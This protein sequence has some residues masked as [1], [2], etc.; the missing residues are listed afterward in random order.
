MSP[1]DARFLNTVREVMG[2][3]PIPD[4]GRDKTSR[5]A[6]RPAQDGRDLRF[7]ANLALFEGDGNSQ[8][9]RKAGAL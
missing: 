1:S 5:L 4:I 6:S 7:V 9:P 3:D 2:Q 8:A